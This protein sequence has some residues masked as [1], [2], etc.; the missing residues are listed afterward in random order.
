MGC[1]I[2]TPYVYPDGGVY[3]GELKNGLPVC[4]SF[5]SSMEK[6]K[7][8]GKMEIILKEILKLGKRLEKEYL[9]GMTHHIMMENF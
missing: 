2:N 5:N 3:D 9:N 8:S 7:Y 4:F 6:V 1:C